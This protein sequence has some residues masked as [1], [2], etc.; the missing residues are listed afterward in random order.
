MSGTA[1]DPVATLATA[2]T[3]ADLLPPE[4][5][6][7]L[8]R[9]LMARAT[10]QC[11]ARFMAEMPAMLAKMGAALP[12][13]SAPSVPAAPSVTLAGSGPEVAAE[14]LASW[15]PDPE[16]LVTLTV[17]AGVGDLDALRSL[18]QAFRSRHSELGRD[19]V[20][21][22]D[23]DWY[24]RTASV[25]QRDVSRP[26]VVRLLPIVPG[27]RSLSR[28]QQGD[29]LRSGGLR[30]AEP[31]EQALAAAAF[32]CKSDGRDVFQDF[33]ARGSLPGHAMTVSRITGT[34]VC[35]SYDDGPYSNVAAC[36]ALDADGHRISPVSGAVLDSGAGV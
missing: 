29:L 15:H 1:I 26:R 36:G 18:N 27:S 3:L 35:T 7:E 31:I 13:A 14:I 5:R 25:A 20:S 24:S 30:F 12:A 22:G 10:P 9:H 2:K 4:G 16:G 8:M 28:E 11:M 32:A 17:P 23:F 21:S 19:A 6:M 34:R 33:W